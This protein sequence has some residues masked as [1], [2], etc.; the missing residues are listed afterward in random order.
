[1]SA[2]AEV[3]MLFRQSRTATAVAVFFTPQPLQGG[4]LRR[5]CKVKRENERDGRGGLWQ[6][7]SRTACVGP[8]RSYPKASGGGDHPF[9][10]VLCPDRTIAAIRAKS[11]MVR[12]ASPTSWGMEPP[13]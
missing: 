9:V 3:I 8:P 5:V 12:S 13:V 6:A 2:G 4:R 10:F 11:S 7:Q 1:M